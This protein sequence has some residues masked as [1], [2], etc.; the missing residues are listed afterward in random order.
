MLFD[1]Q[2]SILHL[3]G[4]HG[5]Y[6][7]RRRDLNPRTAINDLLP[8]QGSPFSLLGTSPDDA[9]S[10]SIYLI[11]NQKIRRSRYLQRRG[12]DSNPCALSDKRFSRPPRYDHFD[13]SPCR[14]PF[15]SAV[16]ILSKQPD[17]VNTFFNKFFIIFFARFCP[18][19]SARSAVRL[20][21]PFPSFF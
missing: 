12:W 14:A 15:I 3:S 4:N 10:F 8:F 20:S 19:I 2:G 13:T 5:D 7:R 9:D 18:L 6:Q 16:I 11:P 17:T 21:A 1:C